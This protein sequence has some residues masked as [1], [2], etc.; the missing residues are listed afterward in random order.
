MNVTTTERDTT[1]TDLWEQVTIHTNHVDVWLKIGAPDYGDWSSR[2]WLRLDAR[3]PLV[4]GPSPRLKKLA[5][6]SVQGTGVIYLTGYKK[7]RQY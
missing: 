6:K 2:N 3:K 4:I 5:F 7:E 1:W